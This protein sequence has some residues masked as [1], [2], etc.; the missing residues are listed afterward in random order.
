MNLVE[1]VSSG[2]LSGLTY[3]TS[4]VDLWPWE[5]MFRPEGDE[6]FIDLLIKK[7]EPKDFS[8]KTIMDYFGNAG[9]NGWITSCAHPSAKG[10]DYFAKLLY[11]HINKNIL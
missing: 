6:T 10:H 7:E 11:E 8:Y 2:F 3:N 9:P 4:S 5:S 1:I